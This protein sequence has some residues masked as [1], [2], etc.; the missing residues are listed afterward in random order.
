MDYE[1]RVIMRFLCK[2]GVLPAEIHTKVEAEFG[3]DAYSLCSVQRWFR[4]AQRGR[5]DRRENDR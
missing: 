5:E 4:F 2:E 3:E 1:R